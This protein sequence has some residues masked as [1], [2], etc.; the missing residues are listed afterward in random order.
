MEVLRGGRRW[1]R[2]TKRF[3]ALLPAGSKCSVLGLHV[4]RKIP[5]HAPRAAEHVPDVA[6]LLPD[7]AV[8]VPDVAEHLPDVGVHFA[9]VGVLPGGDGG[10]MGG[11]SARM[12]GNSGRIVAGSRR[13]GESGRFCA[14]KGGLRVGRGVRGWAGPRFGPGGRYRRSLGPR[15]VRPVQHRMRASRTS[16]LPL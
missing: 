9:D 2:S 8:H 7:V 6:K 4:P 10:R 12:G 16:V 3:M 1:A 13:M 15:L 5:D 14:E 11:G